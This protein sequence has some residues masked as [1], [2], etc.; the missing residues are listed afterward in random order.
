[1]ASFK[2][3][4]GRRC[5]SPIGWFEAGEAT[6]IGPDTMFEAM[7]KVKLI[8]ERLKI[9]QSRQ[10]SYTDARKRALEF[11]VDDLIEL[12]VELSAVHP[13]FYV[14]MLK[15]HIGDSVVVDPPESFDAQDSLLY[16]EVPVEILD[17]Q[18]Q[19]LSLSGDGDFRVPPSAF[20]QLVIFNITK[21]S[22]CYKTEQLL[23]KG[24][25]MCD[26]D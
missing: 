12:L 13:V 19:V 24:R 3:L 11:K 4:Y 25:A 22:N 21:W 26:L 2:A 10:K 9:A 16:D 20:L 23:G 8:R 7:K 6:V 17:Y 1:M 18:V 5:R 14:Y 15:K